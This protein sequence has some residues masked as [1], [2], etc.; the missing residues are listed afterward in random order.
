VTRHHDAAR[1]LRSAGGMDWTSTRLDHVGRR[2]AEATSPLLAGMGSAVALADE[3]RGLA[4]SNDGG[5][6]FALVDGCVGV[7]ALAAGQLGADYLIWAALYREADDLTELCRVDAA[8][9]TAERIAELRAPAA[10][11]GEE[12]A[13]QSRIRAMQW[14]P[15]AERLWAVGQFGLTRFG[16]G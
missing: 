2:I 7:T 9:R 16:P 11:R 12:S 6:S 14:D 3:A 13:E 10:T 1:L 15:L 5:S 8:T 4:L